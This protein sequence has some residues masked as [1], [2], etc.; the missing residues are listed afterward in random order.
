MRYVSSSASCGSDGVKSIADILSSA[1]EQL[2]LSREFADKMAIR[3]SM[4]DIY[5][6]T[7]YTANEEVSQFCKLVAAVILAMWALVW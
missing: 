4:F 1:D 5:V 2:K 6:Y 3:R 7:G